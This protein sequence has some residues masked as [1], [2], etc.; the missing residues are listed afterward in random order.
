M[1]T[2]STKLHDTGR[3]V[4]V[5]LNCNLTQLRTFTNRAILAFII[6]GTYIFISTC[7]ELEERHVRCVVVGGECV[8]LAGILR[9]LQVQ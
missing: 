9:H 1:D 8:R 5:N 7:G 6:G 3:L 4:L 2:D